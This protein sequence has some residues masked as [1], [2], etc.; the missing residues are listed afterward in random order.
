[1]AWPELAIYLGKRSVLLGVSCDADSIANGG[2]ADGPKSCITLSTLNYGNYGIFLIM[3]SAGF[4]ASAVA[5]KVVAVGGDK[6]GQDRH[7]ALEYHTLILF[8]LMEP[9]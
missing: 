5:L 4:C 7:W 1:M 8:F 6:E 9:L 3:G 2:T